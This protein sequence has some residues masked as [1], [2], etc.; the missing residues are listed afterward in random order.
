MTRKRSEK[1]TRVDVLIL[2]AARGIKNEKWNDSVEAG[3]AL[4][5]SKDTIKRRLQGG[6]S[7]A[8][9]REITQLLTIPE[10]K[11]L[12]RWITHLDIRQLILL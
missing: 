3:N 12:L 5:I 8:E 1:R 10:E 6:K 7:V 2:E 11:A 4:N 9:S